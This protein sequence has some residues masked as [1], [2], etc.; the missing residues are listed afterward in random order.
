MIKILGGECFLRS[1][2]LVFPVFQCSLPTGLWNAEISAVHMSACPP[3]LLK[4]CVSFLSTPILS[5]TSLLSFRKMLAEPF[6]VFPPSFKLI[7]I[8]A[9]FS[10]SPLNFCHR[11]QSRSSRFCKTMS[12]FHTCKTLR[13]VKSQMSHLHVYVCC[14]FGF[15]SVCRSVQLSKS[16]VFQWSWETPSVPLPRPLALQNK[17]VSRNTW[18]LQFQG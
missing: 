10:L 3:L 6:F 11:F 16:K 14:F 5:H 8:A 15:F 4:G 7:S 13:K 17:Q 12:Y 2:L 9:L 1:F 18:Q